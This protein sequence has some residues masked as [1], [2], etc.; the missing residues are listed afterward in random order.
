MDDPPA[1]DRAK[2]ALHVSLLAFCNLAGHPASQGFFSG[3]APWGIVVH[4]HLLKAPVSATLLLEMCLCVLN[5]IT[6]EGNH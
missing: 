3:R 1:W 6:M 2:V 5:A 4:L